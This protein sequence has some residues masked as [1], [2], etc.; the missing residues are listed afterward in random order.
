MTLFS[1]KNKRF[2]IALVGLL[3]AGSFASLS[4]TVTDRDAREALVGGPLKNHSGTKGTG[5]A[6]RSLTS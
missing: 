3:Y 4:Q 6:G 2:G 1:M 5:S